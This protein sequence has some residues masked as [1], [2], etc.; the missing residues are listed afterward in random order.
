MDAATP[1]TL[2]EWRH[3]YR[4]GAS[5]RVLLEALRQRLLADSPPE[6]WITRVDAVALDAAL[7]ALETRAAAHPDRAAALR[8]MPLFGVPFAV[9]DNIDVAGL[10]T[11]AACPAFARSADA[12]ANAVARLVAAGAVCLGKTNLDQFATG[13]VGARSPYGRP[14]SA[15][16]AERISGGSSSGSAVVVARGDVP[17][18]LGTDTA[19]SGRVP[20]GFNSIVGL[21]PT[22]GRVGNSGVVPACRSLDCVSIFALTVADAAEVLA[23][24]EGPDAADAYSAFRPGPAQ[25][26]GALRIG[27]P[28][29]PSFGGAVGDTIGYAAAFERAVAHARS[30]GHTLVPIDLAPLLEIAQL[31]YGGPWVAE[32]HAVVQALLA[33]DPAAIDP[34]VRQVI[35]VA[36]E[37]SATDAFR[38]QYRLREAQRDSA[39]LW[40]QI[41]VLLVPTAP[42]HPTHADIDAD[43]L[44]A[45]ARLGTYTN[46][47]NLLGW[48]ALALPAGHADA[49]LPFGVTFIA[50][51]AADAALAHF[52]LAWEASLALPL[53]A[54]G[55]GF[56]ADPAPAGRWPASAPTLAVAV[57][58]AHLSG[59]P[60]N[61]QL[62]ERGARLREATR[63]APRY[64]LF[65][66]PGTT[67]PK[68]GLMRTSEGGAAIEVEVWELPLDAVGSFLA[69]I[70]APLGLGSL[71]LADGRWVHGFLCEAH[72]LEGA[73][74]ISAFGGWR[75]FLRDAAQPVVARS[76]SSPAGATR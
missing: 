20:A 65:A 27:V 32:R 58:G 40:Q 59:L 18:A 31:L 55:R 70:P 43:P 19:G 29:A 33:R 24:I 47:V 56:V 46:F 68:P 16:A 60:L 35:A 13:L 54:T 74:D 30:L 44:G 53:G 25:L 23:A 10:P 2:P 48:C 22:P 26:P 64:R 38:A 14:S 41:D 28:S 3:A 39:A 4:D 34:T 8:A 7:T 76:S 49:G 69:L 75:A 42:T 63:T 11:T 9:K 5:A 37:F 12:D 73:R 51:G 62:T 57:V 15:L 21:K 52:G 72:A 45:N 17:F 1:L 50:P 36:N 61:G 66:L 67:P 71:E 6:A